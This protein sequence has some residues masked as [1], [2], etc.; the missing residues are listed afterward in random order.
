[1][2][3]QVVV[4]GVGAVTPIG[5]GAD[6]LWAG[7]QAGRSAVRSIDRFDAASFPS[8]IAAQ[9]DDFEP[10]DHLDRRRARR[11]DRF[12]ALSVAAARMAVEH[13]GL[14]RSNGIAARTGVFLGSA[15]GGVAFAEEQHVNFVERGVRG[16]A[17]TLALAVF[18]GAGASNVAIDL[19][20]SGPVSGNANSCA[21]GTV[22]IGEAFHAVRDG[23][24]DVALAGGAEA[25]LAP[26]TFGA[27]AMIRV[28]SQRNDDPGSAS[29]PFD[30]GRDGFVMGE[31]AAVLVLE[32][33]SAA[34]HRD[35]PILAEILGFGATNDAYHMT[36]PRP[37]GRDAARAIRLALSDA[38]VTGDEVDYVNAHASST[39]LNEVAEARALHAALGDHGARVPV[40]G[41]KGLYGHPLGA[42]GA[43][44]AAITAL[45][46]QRRCLPGTC[47]L[48]DPDPRLGLN[49][50][51][52]AR[53]NA[54]RRA[55]STSFGFGGMNAALLLGAAG[56]AG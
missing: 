40:S 51:A 48:V 49:L 28:L 21:S 39:Q 56:E 50:L 44:E 5:H 37:D 17:P 10:A 29:R 45:A 36:A 52:E 15:L 23:T 54:A 3:R 18:G 25:P 7:V 9:I 6:G 53:P 55:L 33:R 34:E 27:F 24:L 41:T 35:A 13:A 42:S 26:L 46:L 22:A 1:V 11:L 30:R 12:S 43:I 8:R 31:G 32:E 19:E 4:T 2:R 38:G 16:V 20:I 14:P 47:N